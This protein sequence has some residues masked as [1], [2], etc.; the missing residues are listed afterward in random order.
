MAA[1]PKSI[2]TMGAGILASR[3]ARRLRRENAAVPAQHR[4]FKG[5]L[6]PLASTRIWKSAGVEANMTYAQFNVR[7][8]LRKYADLLP[9]IESMKRGESNV[10]WPGQCCFFAASSSTG[11]NATP[12]AGGPLAAEHIPVTAEMRAHFHQ[13]AMESLFYYTARVRHSRVFRG[14]QLFL[15]GSTTLHP[16]PGASEAAA[17][18]GTLAGI[19]E[20]NLP[21]Y[22]V[23]H[24]Y[25]PGAAVAQIA[26][27]KSKV[28]ALIA[29]TKHLDITL[30]AGLPTWV[31]LFAEAL[32]TGSGGS[33]EGEFHLQK[34]WPNLECFVH[35]GVSVGPFVEELRRLLGPTVNFHEVYPSAAAFVAAQDG[36][37]RGGLRLLADAGVFYEFLPLEDFDEAR[38]SNLGSKAVPLEGVRAGVDYALLLTT[39]AGLCRYSLGD[40]VRFT[41]INPPRLQWIGRAADQLTT[42]GDRVIEKEFADALLAICQR[43]GWT[44]VHFHVAPLFTNPLL[45]TTRG[46]HE[47]WV[48]LRPGTVINPTGPQIAVELDIELQRT[49]PSY[50][51]KRKGHGLESPIVRLVMPGLFEQWMKRQGKWDGQQ[52][53][54]RC[55]N[56]RVVADQLA[57]IAQFAKD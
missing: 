30:V 34:V 11:R 6:G 2:F 3:T 49:N 39:P 47:W 44:I 9:A 54:P 20:F 45:G 55:R 26:D 27:W 41:S 18:V 42:F 40:V 32:R 53:V 51:T 4:A 10:L 31:R 36:E 19:A 24:F 46:R 15:G 8:P 21:A 1:W 37:A 57:A 16:A 22:I 23:K 25:E 52:K 50:Q 5:L 35:H 14:R 43:N 7:V 17:R 38:L 48:E 33:T 28:D 56:D 29:R 13:A 12:S